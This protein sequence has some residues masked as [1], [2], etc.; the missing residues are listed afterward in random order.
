LAVAQPV[1]TAILEFLADSGACFVQDVVRSRRLAVHAPQIEQSL[2]DLERT[3]R[4]LVRPH[5]AGDPHLDGTDLRIVALVQ[6]RD[7]ND[8]LAEAVIA[9]N[10]A[11]DGWLADFLA[12]H[13]CT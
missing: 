7:G 12:N 6:P 1:Q 10:K 2:L 5:S 4:V 8:A 13:R 11:W 3:G 9:I